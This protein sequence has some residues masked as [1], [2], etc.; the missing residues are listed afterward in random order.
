MNH[1]PADVLEYILLEDMTDEEKAA[2][3]E[4]EVTGG[5][6]KQ[7]DNSECGSIWW[8]GLND[9]EKS[10]IKAIPNFD[11]EIFKEITGIDVDKEPKKE[12]KLFD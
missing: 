10:I 12:D 2:H 6:L 11:K 1:L 4:A 9:Y 7:I 8:S 5:Y 3:P